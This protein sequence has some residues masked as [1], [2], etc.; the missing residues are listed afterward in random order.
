MIGFT[1]APLLETCFTMTKSRATHVA[2]STLAFTRGRLCTDAPFTTS[3]SNRASWC[4]NVVYCWRVW[5]RSVSINRSVLSLRGIVSAD[6]VSQLSVNDDGRVKIVPCE[7]CLI[8]PSRL[9]LT[10]G[11]RSRRLEVVPSRL[12]L[13]RSFLWL[14][15]WRS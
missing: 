4:S 3:P 15:Q 10:Q 7:R 12:V 5:H 8:V 11:I 1:I 9:V 14:V 2:G 13:A 6:K